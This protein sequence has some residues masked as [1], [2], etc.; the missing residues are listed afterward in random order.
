[1]EE[2]KVE[3]DV[4]LGT[5]SAVDVEKSKHVGPTLEKHAHDADEA[6]KA[7]DE[8]QGEAIE[9]DESTNRRLLRT[10]DWHLMPIMCC[11]YGMNYL[12][13]M[14]RAVPTLYTG[15]DTNQ[16]VETTLSYASIMGIKEDLNLVGDQY[17]WLGSLF[18]F[19]PSTTC[20]SQTT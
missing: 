8:M 14:F 11:V 7:F 4:A 13:S 2:E 19:G 10:I 20:L 18:Y 6:M 5:S 16:Q 1:M 15:D 3:K 12:D 9:L 17:Q